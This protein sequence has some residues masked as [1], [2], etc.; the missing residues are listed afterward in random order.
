MRKIPL[1]KELTLVDINTLASLKLL[2]QR[3]TKYATLE[4]NNLLKI[5]DV[6]VCY[7]EGFQLVSISRRGKTK[8]LYHF[9]RNNCYN[10]LDLLKNTMLDIAKALEY[11]HSKNIIHDHI[12]LEAVKLKNDDKYL[13]GFNHFRECKSFLS[14]EARNQLDQNEYSAPEKYNGKGYNQVAD[15]WSLGILFLEMIL[16]ERISVM[17]SDIPCRIANFPPQS[18]VGRLSNE[19]IRYLIYRMLEV[20]SA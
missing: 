9:I 6:F 3:L 14:E 11:L 4:H 16:G 2:E 18:I 19:Q 13:L 15:V 8:D 17:A 10:D 7:Q 1:S 5:Q 12:S 20:D